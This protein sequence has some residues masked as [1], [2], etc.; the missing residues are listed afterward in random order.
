MLFNSIDFLIFFPSVVILYY[1]LSHKYRW[2]FLLAA[3]YYFYMSWNPNYII[4]IIGST[5][6]DYYAGLR[7]ELQP[8]KLARKKYLLLSL[9]FNLG[10]LFTFKYFNFFSSSVHSLFASFN[11]FYDSPTFKLLLPV[12]ISFYTFQTLS[13]TIDIYRG[14]RKAEHHLGYFALYVSFFPQLVAGPIE[15]STRLLPQFFRKNHFDYQRVSDGL[16]L[17]T[18]GFF[19]K[20]VIADRLAIL[21]NQVYNNP[22]IYDGFPLIIATYAFAFQVYCD[23]SGYSDIAIGAA[24][25]LGFDL[26][27]NFR[28]PFL[29][30][31]INEL[32]KR[33]HISLITWFKDYLYIPLGGSRV[34]KWRWYFN[35][36]M[37]FFI[38]GLWHGADWTF[39][40]WGLLNA[41]YILFAIW[42]RNIRNSIYSFLGVS[43]NS[44]IKH[45]FQVFITFNLFVSSQIFFRANSMGDAIYIINH[46]FPLNLNEFIN[47]FFS[48]NSGINLGLNKY[49]ILLALFSVMVLE[50]IEIK[51]RKFS[52]KNFLATKPV[53]IRWLLYYSVIVMILFLGEFSTNEFIYFQF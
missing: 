37:V 44:K 27:T 17:M 39:V 53:Y 45:F 46:L 24:K 13:Y 50:F 42:T 48:I 40:M 28:R 34:K 19:K 11:I 31:T 10:L 21:V 4:L 3:S 15:R 38:S 32:W 23:F 49:E 8:S 18:W 25:V 12:G 22:E 43:E 20:V 16:K 33:W 35:I 36:V 7:M 5:L 14:E 29:G 6:I 30:R 1:L 9:F 26:M 2:V 47:E 52:I 51:Q 41:F